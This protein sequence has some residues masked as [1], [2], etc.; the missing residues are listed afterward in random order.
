MSWR[1]VRLGSKWLEGK[2]IVKVT[3]L[4]KRLEDYELKSSE[5][6]EFYDDAA[7]LR[8][9]FSDGTKCLIEASYGGYTGNSEDEYPVF[10][11][12][13]IE[14]DDDRLEEIKEC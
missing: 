11:D 8:L 9:E 3:E 5:G 13:L 10:I 4:I 2:T 14:S 7:W 12:V 1:S 6:R